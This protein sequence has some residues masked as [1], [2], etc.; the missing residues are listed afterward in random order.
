MQPGQSAVVTPASIILLKVNNRNTRAKCKICPKLSIKT[1]ERRQYPYR[2]VT[3]NKVAGSFMDIGV[4]LVSLLLILNI[5]APCSSPIANFEH[6]FACST[7]ILVAIKTFS[8]MTPTE[9]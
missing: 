4:V 8:V 5:F 2:T 7:V 1:P 6:L 9:S 3:F